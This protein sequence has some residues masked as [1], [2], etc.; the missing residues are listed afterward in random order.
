MPIRVCGWRCISSARPAS[1]T[2][3]YDILADKALA[4]V[5]RT[6]YSLPNSVGS[7]AVDQQAKVVEK[8]LNL[9]DLAD[10]AKLGK[11]LNRFSVMYDLKNGSQSSSPELAILQGAGAGISQDTYLAIAGLRGQG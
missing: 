3:A 11:L 9:K 7:M 8:Y 1:I 4:E 10:P 6:T 5:F 2:S